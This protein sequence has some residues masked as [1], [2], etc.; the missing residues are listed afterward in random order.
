MPAGDEVVVR[1]TDGTTTYHFGRVEAICGEVA[2]GDAT[3]MTFEEALNLGRR[4]CVLCS[5]LV[6]TWT[7][8]ALS[9]ASAKFLVHPDR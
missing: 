7:G 5:R 8:Q 4:L 9:V 6:D 2:E 1:L 3:I